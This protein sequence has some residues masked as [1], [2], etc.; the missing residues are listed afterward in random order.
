[1]D[2]RISVPIYK[3]LEHMRDSNEKDNSFFMQPLKLINIIQID[4]NKSFMNL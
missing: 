4:R 2:G 1:M 3:V